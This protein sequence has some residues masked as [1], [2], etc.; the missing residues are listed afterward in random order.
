MNKTCIE[1]TGEEIYYG[2]KLSYST[3]GNLDIDI[4]QPN[5]KLAVENITYPSLFKMKE[6]KYKFFIHQFSAR[7]SKGFKAEIEFNGEI[8]SYSYDKAVSGNVQIAEVTLK[9]AQFT[10][11]HKLP[12]S[13]GLGV[14]KEL[15]GLNTNE[16]HKINLI[17]L[18]PNHWGNNSE[19]HKHYLFMLDNCKTDESIRSFHNE[20]LIAELYDHKRVMEVLANTN[21]ISPTDKQL[22]G[23]GYNSTVKDELI[24]KL[25]GSFQRT[26]KIKF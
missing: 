19:G 7:S 8:Y 5:G 1:P 11:E 3:G 23:L 26:I 22:S 9:N 2:H 18:S 15:Y 24:V 20:N 21:M 12:C 14:T 4:T 13:E 17:C 10:I 6:G 25:K 16:F